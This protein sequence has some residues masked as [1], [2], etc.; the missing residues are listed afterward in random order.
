M[1]FVHVASPSTS[2]SFIEVLNVSG[3]IFP[4]KSIS[5]VLA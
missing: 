2:F 3:N 1:L 5:M 4:G